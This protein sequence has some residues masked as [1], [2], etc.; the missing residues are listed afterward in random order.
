M[1]VRPALA[2]VSRA[3]AVVSAGIVAEVSLEAAWVVSVAGA[4][5]ER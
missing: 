2:V 3:G 4:A 1:S 5:P